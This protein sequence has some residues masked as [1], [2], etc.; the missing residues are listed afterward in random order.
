MIE[1]TDYNL[2]YTQTEE[3]YKLIQENGEDII[4]R[5]ETLCASLKN[6]W[7]ASDALVHINKL[8]EIH[9]SLSKYLENSTSMLVEVN[10]RV[11]DILEAVNR[12]SGGVVVGERFAD[13]FDFTKQEDTEDDKGYK[14]ENLSDEFNSLDTICQDY[15]KFKND[16]AEKFG[17][18]F[19]NWKDDP[20]KKRIE[21]IFNEFI[22]KMDEYQPVLEESR[23]ALGQVVSNTE[24]LLEG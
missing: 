3:I 11:V 17:E 15:L 5:L 13:K 7:K 6:K 4:K 14:M 10:D 22:G 12:I 21:E 18:F 20:K 9:T 1:F 16:Y 23:Q 24:G 8:V 2:A 19:D